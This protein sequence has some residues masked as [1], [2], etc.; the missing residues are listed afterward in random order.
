MKMVVISVSSGTLVVGVNVIVVVLP[1][2]GTAKKEIESKKM[3][4]SRR[5]KTKQVEKCS[6]LLYKI[7]S[8]TSIK[9]DLLISSMSTCCYRFLVIEFVAACSTSTMTRLR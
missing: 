5:K 6:V 4:R 1:W 2:T 3:K 8:S 9:T 7:N